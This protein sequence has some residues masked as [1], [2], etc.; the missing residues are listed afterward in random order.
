MDIFL[1]KV[2]IIIIIFKLAKYHSSL[3][4]YVQMCWLLQQ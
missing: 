2:E 4:V 1:N 3:V